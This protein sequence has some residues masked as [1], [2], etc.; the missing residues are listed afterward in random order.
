MLKV[1]GQVEACEEMSIVD[2]AIAEGHEGDAVSSKTRLVKM[3]IFIIEDVVR[4]WD[5]EGSA[6]CRRCLRCEG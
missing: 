5:G 2:R 4:Q 3:V 1:L 6:Y